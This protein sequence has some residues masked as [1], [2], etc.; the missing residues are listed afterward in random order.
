MA[1]GGG[2]N[3]LNTQFLRGGKAS[4]NAFRIREQMAKDPSVVSYDDI[5]DSFK[6]MAP[7]KLK[8]VKD[9][10]MG[11][12]ADEIT[13]V[14]GS[15]P[16]AKKEFASMPMEKYN[17][18]FPNEGVLIKTW[19]KLETRM[20]NRGPY[21]QVARPVMNK[22]ERGFLSAMKEEIGNPKSPYF[23]AIPGEGLGSKNTWLVSENVTK[24][25]ASEPEKMFVRLYG[26]ASDPHFW[27]RYMAQNEKVF[28][29]MSPED[30]NSLAQLADESQLRESGAGEYFTGKPMVL[31]GKDYAERLDGKYGLPQ[32]AGLDTQNRRRAHGRTC[33][34]HKVKD[35]HGKDSYAEQRGRAHM[36]TLE[37]RKHGGNNNTEGGR[38][39][40]VQMADQGDDAGDDADADDV[41]PDER[42]E[43]ADDDVE[44]ARVSHD[45]EVQDREDEQRCRRT[46][47]VEAGLDHV[48]Q[49]IKGDAAGNDQDEP[50]DRRPY[51][52]GDC[53][54]RLALEERYDDSNN[55]QQT[56][57]ANYCFI[58]VFFSSQII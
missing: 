50:K 36:H 14:R 15:T 30:R 20:G 40:A 37:D 48:G 53:R 32:A 11:I 42:H 41:V 16:K 44:H 12:T 4:D 18:E 28:G 35:A 34:G 2:M 55:G 3:M 38:A 57:Y 47:A 22:P 56:K 21:K 9:N 58:H 5:M 7:R 51:D 1:L 45:A 13:N 46:G 52:E 6:V 54:L 23:G 39:A 26:N 33:P 8:D 49:V 10:S 43:L 31:K 25:G 29:K 27:N 19:P 24:K 17:F